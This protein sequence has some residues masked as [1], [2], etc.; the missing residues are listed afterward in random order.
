MAKSLTILCREIVTKRKWIPDERKQQRKIGFLVHGSIVH[1]NGARFPARNL[2]GVAWRRCREIS[3]NSETFGRQHINRRSASAIAVSEK[4]G[5]HSVEQESEIFE[6]PNEVPHGRSDAGIHDHIQ[7]GAHTRPLDIVFEGVQQNHL[8]A[9][10][11]PACQG[12]FGDID[13]CVP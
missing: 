8:A 9:D 4:F 2:E 7:I 1:V 10:E 13:Q 5:T 6:Q 12:R 3:A 11:N